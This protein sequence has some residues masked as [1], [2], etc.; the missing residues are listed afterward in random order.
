[1]LK[2]ARHVTKTVGT[3]I[4]TSPRVRAQTRASSVQDPRVTRG[5]LHGTSTRLRGRIYVDSWNLVNC[6]P[7][8]N[9]RYLTFRHAKRLRILG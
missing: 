7:S 8:L 3:D 5:R 9:A 2:Q 6:A 4:K 1:M